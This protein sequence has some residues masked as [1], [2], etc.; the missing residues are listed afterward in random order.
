VRYLAALLG[1]G[2]QDVLRR[3]ICIVACLRDPTPVLLLLAATSA[4]RWLPAPIDEH[5]KRLH[6]LMT[7]VP[8]IERIHLEVFSAKP[9]HAHHF[10]IKGWGN[11]ASWSRSHRAVRRYR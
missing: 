11:K 10:I 7:F 9:E 8:A 3:F 1:A 5:A 4:R 2:D 6:P